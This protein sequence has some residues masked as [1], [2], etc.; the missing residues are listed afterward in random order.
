LY[1]DDAL[2]PVES[3]CLAFVVTNVLYSTSIANDICIVFIRSPEKVA[4]MDNL[5]ILKHPVINHHLS[6]LRQKHVPEFE[7]RRRLHLVCELMVAEVTYDLQ[8][9]IRQIETPLEVMDGLEV[10]K[11]VVLVSVLRAGLGMQDAFLRLLPEA[12]VGHVGLYRNEETLEPVSYYFNL[13]AALS[14]C[15]VFLLDP[16]LATGGSLDAALRLLKEH[17]A[18]DIKCV[19]LVAAPEGV[20]VIQENHPDIRIFVAAL[21]R[22]LNDKGYI[23]PGLGDAGDRQFRC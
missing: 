2:T 18:A 4:K 6:V 8:T 16:M 3:E 12:I 7:F 14:D 13:P 20:K 21:D 22:T 15:C 19:S 10:A 1:R 11:D 5:T 9:R 23:L 17:G